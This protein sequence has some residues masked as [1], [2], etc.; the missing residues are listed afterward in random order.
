MAQ[1]DGQP[2]TDLQALQMKAN[3]VTDESL[4]STRRMVQ[5]A[6]DVS[7]A[8]IIINIVF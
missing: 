6:E 3:Q 7:A 4:E 2:L 1:N 5:L 8:N